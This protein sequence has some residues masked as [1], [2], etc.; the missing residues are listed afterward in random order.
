MEREGIVKFTHLYSCASWSFYCSLR[1]LYL[2][3]PLV[4]TGFAI[5]N[6]ITSRGTKMIWYSTCYNFVQGK[7]WVPLEVYPRYI[8]TYTTQRPIYHMGPQWVAWVYNGCIGQSWG[9]MLIL[10]HQ[11]LFY[12]SLDFHRYGYCLVG[13]ILSTRSTSLSLSNGQRVFCFH[14]HVAWFYEVDFGVENSV[15]AT[16]HFLTSK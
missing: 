11:I 7:S 9:N 14:P 13:S 6:C 16:I 12:R 5:H 2:N 10:S 4:S 15:L 8:L 3:H 1:S